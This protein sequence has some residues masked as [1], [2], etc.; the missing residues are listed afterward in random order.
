MVW[1]DAIV[2][3]FQSDPITYFAPVTDHRVRD[4][5]VSAN[6]DSM[7]N[8]R[9]FLNG[10]PFSNCFNITYIHI[11]PHVLVDVTRSISWL[12]ELANMKLRTSIDGRSCLLN[13]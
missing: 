10:A 4:I 1:L 13:G 2:L 6:S 7:A 11:S 9:I 3:T 5:A 12:L 8:H